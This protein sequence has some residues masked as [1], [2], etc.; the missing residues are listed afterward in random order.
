M[1]VCDLFKIGDL[2]LIGLLNAD[3]LVFSGLPRV[4]LS[5]T[6]KIKKGCKS[7]DRVSSNSQ[8]D[9][10]D[11]KTCFKN[12]LYF[13][14]AKWSFRPGGGLVMT[15]MGVGMEWGSWGVGG[16]RMPASNCM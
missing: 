15:R 4:L 9:S 6:T 10:R 12:L 2:Y 11:W 5:R 13:N 3:I 14:S 8:E 1:R 7:Q 16:R